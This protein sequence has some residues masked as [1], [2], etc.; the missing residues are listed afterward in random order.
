M[1]ARKAIVWALLISSGILLSASGAEAQRGRGRMIQGVRPEVHLDFGWHGAFGVGFRVDIPIVPDG[2]ID[3][4]DDEFALSPGA[5]FFFFSYYNNHG[6]RGHY[7]YDEGL[8]VWPLLAAQWNFYLNEDWSIFP[9]LGIAMIFYTHT[10]RVSDFGDETHSH[11]AFDP[12][13]GFGA[14]WHFNARNALLMRLSWPAGF[15]IGI[16]F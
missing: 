13:F 5:E 4:V 9:E 7:Y 3:G 1:T 15:Q 6:V 8:A 2:F 16:T 11:I 12:F 14:R 10:H